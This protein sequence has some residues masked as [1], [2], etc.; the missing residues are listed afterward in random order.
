MRGP[1]PTAAAGRAAPGVRQLIACADHG[2][3]VSTLELACSAIGSY[4]RDR[5]LPD[6]IRHESVRQVRRGLRRTLG[7][8]ARRPAH[9]LTLAEITAIVGAIDGTAVA[10]ARALVLL[11]Y[12]SAPRPGAFVALAL[13]DPR[14]QPCGLLLLHVRRSKADREARGQ[15]VA[16]T[17]GHHPAIC[18]L[19]ARYAWLDRRGCA[20]GPL[21]TALRHQQATTGEP[22]SATAASKRVPLNRPGFRGGSQPTEDESHGSTEEV[23]R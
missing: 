20:P 22:I 19:T 11:R 2:V 4:H 7:T 23:P 17:A 6:P 13:A 16:V 9:A 12:A 3:S 5:D 15:V 18:P 8:A 10:G 1:R 21:F 14:H